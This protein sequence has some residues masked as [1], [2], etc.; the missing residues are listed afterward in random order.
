MRAA[1][2][3]WQCVQQFLMSA[4][5]GNGWVTLIFVK[6][7][8]AWRSK[9][10]QLFLMKDELRRL[11]VVR[12]VVMEACQDAEKHQGFTAIGEGLRECFWWLE[13][14]LSK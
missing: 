5:S 12:F 10:I 13:A 6:L 9:H 7:I 4:C 14:R 2:A 11:I 3:A 1:A 8:V